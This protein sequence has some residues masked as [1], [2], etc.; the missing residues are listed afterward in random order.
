[1]KKYFWMG[2]MVMAS[3]GLAA[4]S[5]YQLRVLS[6][7]CFVFENAT[8][9]RG[10][11]K[12]IGPSSLSNLRVNARV[13]GKGL[14]VASNSA[15]VNNRRLRP[16]EVTGFSVKVMTNFDSKKRCELGFR[17]PVLVQIAALIPNPR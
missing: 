6:W 11:V 1:M 10:T 5:G 8:I 13:M 3:A 2:L 12:N 15:L 16:G 9:V 7:S 17:N 4:Q 14:R